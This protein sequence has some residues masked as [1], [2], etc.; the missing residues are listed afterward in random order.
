VAF[1]PAGGGP[2][3]KVTLEQGQVLLQSLVCSK[4][5]MVGRMPS[6]DL[7]SDEVAFTITLVAGEVA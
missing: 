1:K 3:T 7:E 4:W 6:R 2:L 5:E